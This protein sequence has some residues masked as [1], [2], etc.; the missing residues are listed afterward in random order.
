M[1]EDFPDKD[2]ILCSIESAIV[3]NNNLGPELD[4]FVPCDW[5]EKPIGEVEQA[6]MTGL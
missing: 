2:D 1:V 6:L 5:G 4:V 3:A